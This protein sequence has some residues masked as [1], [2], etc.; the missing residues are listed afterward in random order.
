[1]DFGGFQVDR[2]KEKERV[3]KTVVK[4]LR[5][6]LLHTENPSVVNCTTSLWPSRSTTNADACSAEEDVME[7]CWIPKACSLSALWSSVR[8][9]EDDEE[10]LIGSVQQRRILEEAQNWKCIASSR[11]RMIGVYH[12]PH[13]N[14]GGSLASCLRQSTRDLS[15][16]IYSRLETRL[17]AWACLSA[18]RVEEVLSTTAFL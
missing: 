11:K 9:K 10:K 5:K 12:L 15:K 8:Q 17:S 4:T 6:D 13:M 14:D 7:K 2:L 16:S 3:A 18:L 1:M